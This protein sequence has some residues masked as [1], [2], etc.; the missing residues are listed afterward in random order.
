M[1]GWLRLLERA[2]VILNVMVVAYWGWAFFHELAVG[3]NAS[4]SDQK[5]IYLFFV[6]PPLATILA[7]GYGA[8]RLLRALTV[9][10]SIALGTWWMAVA[11]EM[12]LLSRLQLF[13]ACFSLAAA[14]SI[15]TVVAS[16]RTSSTTLN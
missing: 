5:L 3:R 10:S 1:T 16:G 15:V 9:V 12:P 7:I 11:I 8:A 4:L 6:V 14:L 2:T 13:W